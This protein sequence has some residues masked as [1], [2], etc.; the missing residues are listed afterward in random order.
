MNLR[1]TKMDL[2]VVVR[3]SIELHLQFPVVRCIR[4]AFSAMLGT[5]VYRV[6]SWESHA[7]VIFS[8]IHF[9]SMEIE[10]QRWQN[11]HRLPNQQKSHYP[12]TK[13][14]ASKYRLEGDCKNFPQPRASILQDLWHFGSNTGCIESFHEYITCT[15]P[16]LDSLLASLHKVALL[17]WNITVYV[18]GTILPRILQD[19]S[20]ITW[21]RATK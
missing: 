7:K 1:P 12:K 17:L 11:F 3:W 21:L 19:R 4:V 5:W 14:V 6:S 16:L 8:R 10:N 13:D 2:N 18:L 20:L 15:L 9:L